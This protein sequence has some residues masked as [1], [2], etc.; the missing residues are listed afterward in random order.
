V[1]GYC[2]LALYHRHFSFILF[3]VCI[4]IHLN[5]SD[6]SQQYGLAAIKAFMTPPGQR[7]AD[8]VNIIFKW[9][10]GIGNKW[11]SELRDRVLFD[12]AAV[13]QYRAYARQSILF[14]QGDLSEEFYFLANGAI[15]IW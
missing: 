11:I 14:E 15:S 12:L 9:L 5:R 2:R 6:V 7:S 4:V 10:R 1:S 13:L 3:V 8:D